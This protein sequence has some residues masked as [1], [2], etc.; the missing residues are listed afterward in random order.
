MQWASA[1]SELPDF[2]AAFGEAATALDHDL[3]DA[4]PDLLLAFV[5]PHPRRDYAR[6][7]KPAGA[8]FGAALLLGCSGGGVI[9]RRHEV[10]ARPALSLTG[11]RL[12]GVK[13]SPFYFG[14]DGSEAP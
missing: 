8:R 10:E 7:A 9:G 13:L 3:G 2:D 4:R 12:P 14:P 11:A 6:L 1:I 5:P